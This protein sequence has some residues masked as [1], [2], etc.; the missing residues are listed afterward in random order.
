MAETAR[1]PEQGIDRDELL[2]QMEEFQKS[3]VDW[4]EGR[5]WSLVYH[6]GD[7][8]YEFLKEAYNLFFSANALN[9]M[10]FK[11]LKRME[12]EVVRMTADMLHGDEEVVGTMT[13]GG[14]ESI[15]MAVKAAR[16]RARFYRKWPGR[17]EI[18]APRTIHPAFAKAAHYFG[19]DIEYT[20]VDGDFRAD[21]DAL[22]DAISYKTVLVAAS[23]PQYAHGM[24]DP[25]EEI[26]A[27]AREHGVPFHVDACFG[28]FLLPWLEDLGYDIPTFDFR[29]PGVTSISADVHK[30]GYAAKGASTVL[31]R[32]MSYLRHQFF[33][34]TEF[35]GGIYASPTMA[36]TR[37]GGAIAAAWASMRALGREGYTEL[38]EEAMEAAAEVKE[39][40][41]DIE[42]LEIL[43]SEHSTIVT[44]AAADDAL[45]IYVVADQ[46]QERNWAVDRQHK[47]PSLHLTVNP[48]NVPV[49]DTFA[50]DLRAAA[51]Y[52]RA[53]P[54]ASDEGDAAMY[55]MMAKIPF[56]GAVEASVRKVMESMYGPGA[57]EPDLGE[58]AGGED[59]GFLLE[60]VDRYGDEIR[61]V[62]DEIDEISSLGDLW[63]RLNRGT[64]PTSG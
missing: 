23:A 26:A 59:A 61:R 57:A 64:D 37:P 7:E 63:D 22:A 46:L 39:T 29:V 31:Y 19:L 30:Y 48:Q 42:G 54:E 10:A 55:G 3:D 38:A 32:N 16:D 13:S 4:E 51:E 27:V 53:H 49:L 21:V 47:P 44:F 8:H 28:G 15:L 20:P 2:E 58:I 11:S 35:P 56:Q 43:G 14:T 12:S 5:T 1:I 34:Q 24:V 62:L 45:D 60:M 18:V 6:A 41:A 50:E 33:V 52:A 9:P 25:I 40:V 36:G 17:P